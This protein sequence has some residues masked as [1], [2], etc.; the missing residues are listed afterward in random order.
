[1]NE[2]FLGYASPVVEVIKVQVEKGFAGSVTTD[3]L[4][5]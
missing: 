2:M 1:M 3:D 4:G 5:I